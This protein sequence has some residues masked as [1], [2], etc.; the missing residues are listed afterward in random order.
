MKF[1]SLTT[2]TDDQLIDQSLLAPAANHDGKVLEELVYNCSDLW[3]IGDKA[4]NDT[5]KEARF[6]QKRRILLL[7]LRK[8]NHHEPWRRG[9]EKSCV[10]GLS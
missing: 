10:N 6:W 8:N 1:G 3:L 2:A 9:C 7:P 5:E 4:Y